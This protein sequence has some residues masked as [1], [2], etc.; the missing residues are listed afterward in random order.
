MRIPRLPLS[1][2]IGAAAVAIVFAACQSGGDRPAGGSDAADRVYV[3]PGEY[4]DYYAFLSGGHSG[5]IFVY[6]LPSGRH[7]TTI[8]VFTPESASG[9]GYDEESNTSD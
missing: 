4:D 9:W 8:P 5:Q 1:F 6:G 7:M 2:L 3:P